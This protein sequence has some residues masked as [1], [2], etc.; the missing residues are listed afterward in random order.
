MFKKFKSNN[1]RL[2]FVLLTVVILFCIFNTS[3]V[4]YTEGL[5]G[6]KDYVY[7][8]SHVKVPKPLL[9]NPALWGKVVKD[10]NFAGYDLGGTPGSLDSCKKQCQDNPACVEIVYGKAY[11]KD[12]N[13]FMKCTTNQG[14]PGAGPGLN[15][16][17]MKDATKRAVSP[18]SEKS[19]TPPP[20]PPPPVYPRCA[21]HEGTVWAM[22]GTKPKGFWGGSAGNDNWKTDIGNCN[23]AAMAEKRWGTCP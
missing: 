4:V 20:P 13:C 2:I 15:I 6:L 21:L 10:T 19:C 18:N 23:Y 8:S 17:E 7:D 3:N 14:R 9:S 1:T 22:C 16:Y 12:N 5:D 11:G